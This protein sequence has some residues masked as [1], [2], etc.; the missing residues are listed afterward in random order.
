[1]ETKIIQVSLYRYIQIHIQSFQLQ[2][3]ISHNYLLCYIL[4]FLYWPLGEKEFLYGLLE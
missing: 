2:D 1:M 4:V 3:S